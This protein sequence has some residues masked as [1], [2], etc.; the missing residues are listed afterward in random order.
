MDAL[1]CHYRHF[2][3]RF[4]AGL[5]PQYTVK[6][7]PLASKL[8]DSVTAVAGKARFRNAQIH[9]DILYNLK[10]EL[11]DVPFDSWRK[12][13]GRGVR[14][15]LASI[16]AR[17]CSSASGT[18]FIGDAHAP[19]EETK[20]GRETANAIDY[21]RKD[22]HWAKTGFAADFLGKAYVG[23]AERTVRTAAR[24]GNF[25]GPIRSKRVAV[26]MACAMFKR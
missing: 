26:V 11:L 9:Y 22:F 17:P 19:P 8:L 3:N 13:P 2:R 20:K 5:E 15:R 18:C 25:P 1:A 14:R 10:P 12:R 24:K 7:Q 23:R 6:F 16:T 4:H 21:L